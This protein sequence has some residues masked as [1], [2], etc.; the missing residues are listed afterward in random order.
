MARSWSLTGTQMVPILLMRVAVLLTSSS[1]VVWMTHLCD[2]RP[3]RNSSVMSRTWRRLRP[4]RDR[5]RG[6][7][8]NN[9]TEMCEMT[10]VTCD[11]AV[12][13]D[14][15]TAGPNQSADTPFGDGPVERLTQWMFEQPEANAAEIDAIVA[16]GGVPLGGHKVG[17]G[18]GGRGGGGGGWGGG[19]AA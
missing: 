14:G 8:R 18:P 16:A 19:G 12:S 1:W 3:R 7:C 4:V 13:V 11:M 9:E 17:P 10:K 6:R 2:R 15:F 5:R